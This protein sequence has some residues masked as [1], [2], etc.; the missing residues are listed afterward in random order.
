MNGRDESVPCN[1]LLQIRFIARRIPENFSSRATHSKA[2]CANS[3]QTLD[4]IQ[5]TFPPSVVKRRSLP[6]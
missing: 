6:G 3:V 4:Y 2:Y 1:L 5:Y